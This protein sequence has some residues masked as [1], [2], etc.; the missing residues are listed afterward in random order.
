MGVLVAPVHRRP[1]ERTRREQTR[2]QD[3]KDPL[4][5]GPFIASIY[6]FTYMTRKVAIL[7]ADCAPALIVTFTRRSLSLALFTVGAV[8][9]GAPPGASPTGSVEV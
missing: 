6:V 8:I 7:V 4:D 2:A 5:A 9:S 1:I 3:G